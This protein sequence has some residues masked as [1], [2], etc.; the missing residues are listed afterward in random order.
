MSLN[1][2]ILIWLN[3]FVSN[4][5]IPESLI[6]FFTDTPIF[7]IP[8]FLVWYWLYYNFNNDKIKKIELLNIFYSIVIAITIALIIQQ[9]IQIDRPEDY[10]KWTK[11]LI[12]K[13]LPDASFPSDHATVIFTFT[14]WLF[15]TNY[16]KLWFIFLIF[17]I[18]MWLARISVWVH[19][20]TDI[21][22]WIFLWLFS[23]FL[24]F[25]YLKNLNFVNKLND[26]ILK[27]TSYIK[28]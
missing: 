19:W 6:F 2:E 12:M 13:H 11:A 22:W 26:F 16:K 21:L 17:A 18:L 4:N 3:G 5:N 23:S 14:F 8:I 25:K 24:T 9:F 1:Q 15:F 10:L 7:F 28:L 20:P 27:L